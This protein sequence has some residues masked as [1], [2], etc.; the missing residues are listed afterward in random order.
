MH[1]FLRQRLCVV[2]ALISSKVTAQRFMRQ[3]FSNQEDFGAEMRLEDNEPATGMTREMFLMQDLH[4]TLEPPSCKGLDGATRRHIEKYLGRGKKPIEL[5]LSKK[6]GK[7]GLRAIAKQQQDG[8]NLLGRPVR[9]KKL[10]AFWR[11]SAPA[12]A[13]HAGKTA[14]PLLKSSEFLTAPYDQA[15]R[16]R[17][18]TVEFEIQLPPVKKGRGG[19]MPSV[20]YQVPVEPG[21]MN[22]RVIVPRGTGQVWVY[23][24][25]DK[26]R[27]VDAGS[28]NVSVVRMRSGL[29]DPSWARGTRPFFWKGRSTG[30]T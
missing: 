27:P 5:T 17:L 9:P 11:Q 15:V 10:R 29:V 13:P 22:P 6:R 20:V 14:K 18:F 2:L 30:L 8:K 21:S 4:W 1:S 16:S 19:A 12:D 23:P 24:T 7:F 3:G 28:S 25:G 26:S